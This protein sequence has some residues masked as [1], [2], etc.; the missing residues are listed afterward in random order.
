MNIKF[1]EVT[2]NISYPKTNVNAHDTGHI[3][4]YI[5]GIKFSFSIHAFII[6]LGENVF[7]NNTVCIIYDMRLNLQPFKKRK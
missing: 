6:T 3:W 4:G 2:S 7:E 5:L 1:C